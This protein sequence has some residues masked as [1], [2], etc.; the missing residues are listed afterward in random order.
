[1]P[2]VLGE[3][4]GGA[5]G[6]AP[7]I[8]GRRRQHDH[9]FD[10]QTG[11]SIECQFFAHQSIDGK[12]RCQHQRNPG[13]G[14]KGDKLDRH[15]GKGQRHRPPLQAAQFLAQKH[16]SQQYVEQRVDVVAEAGIQHMAVV[17]GP[18]EQQPVAAD[19]DRGKRQGEQHF[20]LAQHRLHLVPLA[21]CQGEYHQQHAG[22][23]HPVGQD[24][25][26]RDGRDGLEID[27]GYA[28]KGIGAQG[29][30]D[31]LTLDLLRHADDLY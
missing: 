21:P 26:G 30:D 10:Q 12:T 29:V 6:K 13:Q 25:G 7:Q 8:D 2:V 22:P 9:G 14:A 23:D 24:F 31:A 18:D 16:H 5:V 15:P 17:D 27:G 4:A 28:P 11:E 19:G 1:M 3:M 20:W